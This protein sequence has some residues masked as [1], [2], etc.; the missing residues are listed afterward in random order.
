MIIVPAIAVIRV[1]SSR[2]RLPTCR[3]QQAAPRGPAHSQGLL[4]PAHLLIELAELPLRLLCSPPGF[5]LWP[6]KRLIVRREA[7]EAGVVL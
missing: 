7:R 1:Q 5:Q 4:D 3:P 6:D 2:T